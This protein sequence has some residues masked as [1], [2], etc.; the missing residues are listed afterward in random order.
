[1]KKLLLLGVMIFAFGACTD[2]SEEHA[3]LSKQI[4]SI[5]KGDHTI[6]SGNGGEDPDDT[7][8]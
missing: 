1:M 7:E 5:D 4:H 3:E 2:N 6:K 8:D